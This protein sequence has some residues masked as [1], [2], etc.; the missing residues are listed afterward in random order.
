MRNT[1]FKEAMSKSSDIDLKYTVIFG[2]NYHQPMVIAAAEEELKK[3]NVNISA[4]EIEKITKKRTKI[5][6][7]E[8]RWK[9]L[10][11]RES[12]QSLKKY[13]K[14]W[15]ILV[16]ICGIIALIDGVPISFA[17]VFATA[18]TLMYMNFK[19]DWNL[20][21]KEKISCPCC[22]YRT[23]DAVPDSTVKV[24]P[25]CFWE[26]IPVPDQ[27]TAKFACPCCGYTTFDIV[28]GGT[29]EVCPVCFWEDDPDQFDDPDYEGGA[30]NISLKQAQ[31]HFVEFGACDK[32]WIGYVRKP[33]KSEQ[34]NADW[35]MLE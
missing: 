4:S 1:D 3:R 19:S 2:T 8:K 24:C 35:K 20:G 33:K 11:E 7:R 23:F 16:A 17:L 5:E 15:L 30:N 12:N 28:Y 31:R 27:K 34:R 26:G 9:E 25:V 22:L 32:E 18:I 14:I 6:E 29:A 10:Q 13:F 21:K